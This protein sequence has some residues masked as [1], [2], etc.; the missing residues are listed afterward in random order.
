MA[1]RSGGSRKILALTGLHFV[2][3][4]EF[5]GPGVHAGSRRLLAEAP[6]D[7]VARTAGQ[8]CPG[9][10]P[11]LQ[12]RHVIEDRGASAVS[13]GR[14]VTVG[15]IFEMRRAAGTTSTTA[16][17]APPI[18]SAARADGLRG[19]PGEPRCSGARGRRLAFWYKSPTR[20]STTPRT[21]KDS[22]RYRVFTEARSTMKTLTITRAKR[23]SAA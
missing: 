12:D 18:W 20:S 15:D 22:M 21:R 14:V 8:E 2:Y 17:R 23:P 13:R 5:A 9:G 19:Y 11:H 4:G 6:G 3:K 1:S 10:S 7:G 16:P